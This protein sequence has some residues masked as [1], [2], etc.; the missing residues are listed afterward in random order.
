MR[1]IRELFFCFFNMGSSLPGAI[2]RGEHGLK[3]VHEEKDPLFVVRTLLPVKNV[4]DFNAK[5]EKFC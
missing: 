5:I 4:L 3:S 1:H 2:G